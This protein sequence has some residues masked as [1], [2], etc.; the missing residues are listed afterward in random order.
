MEARTVLEEALTL[1]IED[2][3]LV[4]IELIDSLDPSAASDVDVE[5]AWAVEIRRRVEEL[6]SGKV[7]TIPWEEVRERLLERIARR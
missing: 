2:R 5:K 3:A 1:R 6:R 7:K 4:A